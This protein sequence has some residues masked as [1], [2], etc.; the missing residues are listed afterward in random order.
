[1]LEPERRQRWHVVVADDDPD[2]RA[3]SLAAVASTGLGTT[4]VADGVALLAECERL[5][6]VA[7]R[8][9]LV[10]SDLEMPGMSGLDAMTYMPSLGVRVHVVLVTGVTSLDVLAG[11]SAAGAAVVLHKPVS[12][13]ALLDAVAELTS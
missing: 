8:S 3:L 6:S 2:W 9:V 5:L 4:A 1:M 12:R 10:L 11:A 13:S 7:D